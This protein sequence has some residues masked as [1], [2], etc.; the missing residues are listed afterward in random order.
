MGVLNGDSLW[1][2][3]HMGG[4]V[5]NMGFRMGALRRGLSRGIKENE[6]LITLGSNQEVNINTSIRRPP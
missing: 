6:I 3:S 4:Y 1:G 2:E 5:L